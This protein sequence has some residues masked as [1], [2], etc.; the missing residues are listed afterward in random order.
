MKI[1]I[2]RGG[3]CVTNCFIVKD[4]ETKK[5]IVIDPAFNPSKIIKESAGYEIE[6]IIITHAHIDHLM[7]LDELKKVTGAK[8]VISVLENASLNDA[9]LNL[10]DLMNIPSVTSKA[11]ITVNDGDTLPFA[12]TE[13]KFILTPGHTV[14]GMCVF[15]DDVIFSGDTL[16]NR[17]IGRTDLPGGSYDDLI[18]SIKEKLFV[19]PENTT[20]YPGHGPRTNIGIEKRE[21]PFVI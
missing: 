11:D 4:E 20:I 3:P 17:T 19:Y 16:F 13:I 7:A 8:I 18:S 12:N 10:S 15:V 1:R 2:L 5:A 9:H 14:G 6:Y 21:N